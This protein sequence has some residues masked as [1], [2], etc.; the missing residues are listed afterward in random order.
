MPAFLAE[1]LAPLNL[2]FTIALILVALYWICVI[3]GALDMDFLPDLLPDIDADGGEGLSDMM[4]WFG[5]DQVPA[6]VV[7]SLIALLAWSF[8][9][10][11]NHF[12]NPEHAL[13]PA[14]LLAGVNLLLSALL[15]A[16]MVKVFVRVAGPFSDA[17]QNTSV[18]YR[19]GT[20]ITSEV[21]E[22]FG[23]VQVETG[24]APATVNA[25][26]TGGAVLR[27]GE[28]ALIFDMDANKG[29]YFVEKYDTLDE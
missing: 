12:L 21:T 25:R 24:G 20:V 4:G 17:G 9:M 23:Q 5:L 1:A 19:V 22:H 28:K 29:I 6:T 16:L 14:L 26:T 10:T 11:A 3:L 27:K 15:A 7:I 8:S 2:P 18:L 13:K